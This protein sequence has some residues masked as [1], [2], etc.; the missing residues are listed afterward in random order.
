MNLSRLVPFLETTTEF[1]ALLARLRAGTATAESIETLEAARPFA[2]AALSD[3]SARPLLVI[4]ARPERAKQLFA[5]L[6]AWSATPDRVLHF[7]EPEPLL[8]E[9]LPWSPEAIATRLATLGALS[10]NENRSAVV[11]TTVRALMPHTVTPE[12]FRAGTMVLRRGETVTPALM[13]PT[14]L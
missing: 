7:A 14:R 2:L 5:E 13:L 11:V 4:T 3:V 1:Q 6:Q 10:G 8:Y 12:E 9:R